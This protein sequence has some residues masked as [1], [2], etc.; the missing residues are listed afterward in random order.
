[1][2]KTLAT[3]VMALGVMMTS[4]AATAGSN[5]V[6]GYL[7]MPHMRLDPPAQATTERY[8]DI[9]SHTQVS[10]K[11]GAQTRHGMHKMGQNAHKSA[12]EV[13]GFHAEH[14]PAQGR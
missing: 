2:I 10:K 1:M 7:G 3:A 6:A 14:R 11:I 9:S 4:G 5:G 12:R 8:V 13:R